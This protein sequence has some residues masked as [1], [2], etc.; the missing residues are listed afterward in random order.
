MA[1]LE[2][3]LP[4]IAV[5]AS[6]VPEILLRSVTV[7]SAREF[8]RRSRGWRHFEK[9]LMKL[10]EQDDY[11]EYMVLLGQGLAVAEVVELRGQPRDFLI[12]P[13]Q[14]RKIGESEF[15]VEEQEGADYIGGQFALMPTTWTVEVP[16][17]LLLEFDEPLIS[18]ALSRLH[19][20][21][22]AAWGRPDLAAY[23]KEVFEN[24][25]D[26][27]STRAADGFISGR[28]R[29]VRYGGY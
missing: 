12:S 24:G 5:Q 25:V 13:S 20:M 7:D 11:A 14:Y 22:D 19:L 16:D 3:L 29:R 28:T 18:G 8:F 21:P 4:R 1:Q 23:H 15:R 26:R 2:E 9:E 10:R 17:F 27:A 6:G